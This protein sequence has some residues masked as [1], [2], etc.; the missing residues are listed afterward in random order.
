MKVMTDKI[1]G[2]KGSRMFWWSVPVWAGG[3]QV[4]QF[5]HK[6]NQSKVAY[7]SQNYA[8]FFAYFLST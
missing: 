2:E 3:W 1:F 6:W 5:L 4:T 7:F 8:Q